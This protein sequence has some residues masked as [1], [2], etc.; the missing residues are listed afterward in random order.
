MITLLRNNAGKHISHA[1]LAL[2]LAGLLACSSPEEQASKYYEK[3]MALLE[4]GNLIKARIE[5]QNALQIRPDMSDASY[6]LAQIAEQQ[7][8]WAKLFFLLNKVIDH[9]PEHLAAQIKLGRIQLAADQIDKALNTSDIALKLAPD[10]AEA[11]GLRAGVLYKLEDQDGAIAQATAALAASP[12]NIDALV[13]MAAE[14]LSAGDAKSA[15]A[16]L[17]RGLAANEKNIALQLFKVQALES[18]AQTDS[19]EAIYRRLIALYP[20][21]VPLRQALAQFYLQHQ[22]PE[23]AEA[24]YRAIAADHPRDTQARLDVARF[25]GSTRGLRDEQAYLQE[26]IAIE[27]GNH[28]YAFA[29]AALHQAAGDQPAAEGVYR[30]IIAGSHAGPEA[31]KAKGL[32]AG[33]LLSNGNKAE[34]EQLIGEVLA[35]DQRNEQG[36]LLKA[37]LAIEAAQLEQAVADLRTILRDS[38]ESA[39]ALL[40]LAR[41]HQQQGAHELAQENYLKAYQVGRGDP[42]FALAYAEFLLRRGQASRAEMV[43]EALLQ[44]I[45]GQIDA[46]KL[47]AQTRIDQ[48]NWNGAQAVAEQLQQQAGQRHSAEQIRGAVFAA[49]KDYSASIAAFRR[50]HD[51][52]PSA[53]QPMVA[54]VRSYLLA[55]KPEEASAFLDSVLKASPANAT[56]LLLRGELHALRGEQAQAA[57]RFEQLIAAQP[58]LAD[59]YV[60][61]ASLHLRA[62]EQ[63]KAAQIIAQGL[64]QLPDDPELRMAEASRL[65][66]DGQHEAAIAAYETLLAQQPNALLVV[67]NLASLLSE[68]RQDQASLQRAYTLA[69]RLRQSQLAHFRDTL[70]WAAHRLGKTEESTALLEEVVEQSPDNATFRYHLA[71]SYLAANKKPEARR[72]LET[73]LALSQGQGIEASRVQAALNTL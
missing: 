70:G 42:Q 51:S 65:E 30:N 8:D 44:Q 73:A 69:Q 5:L 53:V 2:C 61:L 11:L 60:N 32:L 54:L 35:G 56:A 25:I 12:Q 58:K 62:N 33:I 28:E 20:E 14:R 34:A 72:E 24:E 38:P 10:N 45:P 22:R 43:A 57:A 39:R 46:L 27:P 13:V 71:M 15:I 66:L 19:A 18:L 29:L 47:L 63:D 31:I 41:A 52:A 40:L 17:D 59:G 4:Q 64:A 67:N 1:T 36:L 49:R 68:Q 48:G 3:G 6:A 23:A 7:G 21:A 55:G 37:G 26:Q 50:A 9:N 16:Y